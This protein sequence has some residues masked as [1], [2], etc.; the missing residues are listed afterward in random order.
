[1]THST[2][3]QYQKWYRFRTFV[4]ESMPVIEQ[5]EERGCLRSVD[6]DGSVDEVFDR[7]CSAFSDQ[8]FVKEASEAAAAA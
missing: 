2:T 6:A 7:V 5:M 4:D 8:P 3:I 1:M